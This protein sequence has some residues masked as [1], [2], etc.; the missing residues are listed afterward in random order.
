M[1]YVS[2][3]A[4]ATVR[5]LVVPV[6]ELVQSDLRRYLDILKRVRDVRTL[7]LTPNPG[8]FNPQAYP[9]GHIYYSQR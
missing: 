3:F 1:D 2:Y 7:D 8:K 4:P 6:N 9:H 5:T